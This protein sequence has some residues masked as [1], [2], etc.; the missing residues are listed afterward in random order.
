MCMYT[1]LTEKLQFALHY[2]SHVQA[3]QHSESEGCK[4]KMY[5]RP[6]VQMST[7]TYH[8]D[9]GILYAGGTTKIHVNI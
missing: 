8:I 1:Q 2:C 7:C 6:S 5:Y 9:M 4:I 3:P